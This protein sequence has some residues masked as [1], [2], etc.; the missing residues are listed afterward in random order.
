MPEQNQSDMKEWGPLEA[1]DGEMDSVPQ[2]RI[3]TPSSGNAATA[4]LLD[5]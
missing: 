1:K 4:D 5:F 3:N 2:S